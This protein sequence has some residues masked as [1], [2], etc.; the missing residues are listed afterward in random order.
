MLTL[1]IKI[2]IIFVQTTRET[3][4]YDAVRAYPRDSRDFYPHSA[5]SIE[6]QVMPALNAPRVGVEGNEGFLPES[7]RSPNTV[8]SN[9][10]KTIYESE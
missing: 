7:I 9:Q 1:N 8:L 4:H 10:A 3:K 6:F 5:P 2:Q